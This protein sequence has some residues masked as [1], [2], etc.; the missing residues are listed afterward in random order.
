MWLH[1][2]CNPNIQ[3]KKEKGKERKENDISFGYFPYERVGLARW[4]QAEIVY[5]KLMLIHRKLR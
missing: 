1:I 3:R 5:D 2:Q 4:K